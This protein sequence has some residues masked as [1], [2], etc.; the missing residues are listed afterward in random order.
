MQFIY[1]YPS[2]ST[3]TEI[4]LEE[5]QEIKP[6]YDLDDIV[7][8]E[9]TPKNF[10]RVAAQLAKGVVTQRIREAERSIIYGEYKEKEYDIIT[11]TVLRE[12]KGNVFVFISNSGRFEPTLNLA[13]EARL[14]GMIVISIS[15]IE[16][17]D[18]A[19]VSDYNLRFFS[20][21][22]EYE[23]AAGVRETAAAVKALREDG[24]CTAAVLLGCL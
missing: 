8:F 12:D 9:V 7:D 22:R 13:K 17:N 20:K 21:P 1:K 18:L 16:N 24:V 5:A 2:S 15:S 23:G 14:H 19:E 6:T 10:G 11:G 3:V 4:G